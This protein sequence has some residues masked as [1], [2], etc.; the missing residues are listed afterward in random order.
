MNQNNGGNMSKFRLGNMPKLQVQNTPKLQAQNMP[1]A[2]QNITLAQMRTLSALK[3]IS[4]SFVITLGMHAS[5]AQNW[6]EKTFGLPADT[7]S[8]RSTLGRELNA[9]QN[10]IAE[11]ERTE[12]ICDAYLAAT[13]SVS[14]AV[15]DRLVKEEGLSR[16]YARLEV[17]DLN[18]GRIMTRGMSHLNE[19]SLRL[20][21]GLEP[22]TLPPDYKAPVNAWYLPLSQFDLSKLIE[23]PVEMAEAIAQREYGPNRR[24]AVVEPRIKQLLDIRGYIDPKSD[25]ELAELFVQYALALDLVAWM[26]E[27]VQSAWARYLGEYVSYLKLLHFRD[28]ELK[29]LN[30]WIGDRPSKNLTKRWEKYESAKKFLAQSLSQLDQFIEKSKGFERQIRTKIQLPN[31]F[32]WRVGYLSSTEKK[33]EVIE[34]IGKLKPEWRPDKQTPPPVDST[35]DEDDY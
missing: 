17:L 26:D 1:T 15:A 21:Y 19:N 3:I 11:T 20:F 10:Q 16:E 24:A 14:D 31:L 35:Q 13:K 29:T 2:Q 33:A 6:I 5:A 25:P 18:V 4:L 7:I 34:A 8:S 23:S 9:R 30:Q 32:V 22:I 27:R 12:G 28:E